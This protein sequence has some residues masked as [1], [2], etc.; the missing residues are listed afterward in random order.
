MGDVFEGRPEPGQPVHGVSSDDAAMFCSRASEDAGVPLR[1]PTEVEWEYACRAGTDTA[2][3][4]GRALG[5][6]QANFD[7]SVPYAG[8]APGRSRRRTT[9]VG[10]FPPNAFGLHDM[11]GNVSEWCADFRSPEARA[12]RAV[13][14]GSFRDSAR[15]C[16]SAKREYYSRGGRDAWRGFRVVS[17]IR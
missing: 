8:A 1:L 12:E 17:P 14:G 11:H 4:T 10:T 9:A 13:R 15:R 3:H 2:F 16:R 5:A 6:D 7:A